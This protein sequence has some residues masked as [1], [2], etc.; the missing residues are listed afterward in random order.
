M[1]TGDEEWRYNFSGSVTG[2]HSGFL[3]CPTNEQRVV[4]FTFQTVT[5]SIDGGASFQG[6]RAALL[7]RDAQQGHRHRAAH[8][9]PIRGRSS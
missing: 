7:R 6:R 2:G 8:R 3:F 4:G 5:Q 9:R 1:V